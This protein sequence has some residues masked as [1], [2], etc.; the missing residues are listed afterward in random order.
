MVAVVQTL[1]DIRRQVLLAVSSM[2]WDLP[3]LS[4]A[5]S[6]LA[7]EARWAAAMPIAVCPGGC[8]EGWLQPLQLSLRSVVCGAGSGSHAELD[9]IIM[10]YC[11]HSELAHRP[12]MSAVHAMLLTHRRMPWECH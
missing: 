11:L 5:G 9:S 2:L 1:P 6:S 8:G 7:L 4:H 3:N 10:F 12:A